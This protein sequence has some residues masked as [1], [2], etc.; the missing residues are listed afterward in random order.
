MSV[1]AV[2]PQELTKTFL[3]ITKLYSDIVTEGNII[4]ERDG[5]VFQGMDSSHICLLQTKLPSTLLTEYD[6]GDG[7]YSEYL[8]VT[9]KYLVKI[10]GSFAS[11]KSITLEKQLDTDRLSLIIETEDGVSEFE[12]RLMDIETDEL[13]I[14]ELEYDVVA[15]VSFKTLQKAV[16]QAE[17]LEAEDIDLVWDTSKEDKK[18]LRVRYSTDMVNADVIVYTSEE[19]CDTTTKV[20]LIGKFPKR[21]FAVGQMSSTIKVGFS[22]DLPVMFREDHG[23]DGY[24]IMYVAPRV[25]DDDMEHEEDMVNIRE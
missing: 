4:F 19:G 17:T 20:S 13:T 21:L 11:P 12:I 9:Y 16:G 7:E 22:E 3:T 5:I 6:G 2:I 1:K 8:G 10:I 25:S 23:D 18:Q 14:P 24:T 15:D